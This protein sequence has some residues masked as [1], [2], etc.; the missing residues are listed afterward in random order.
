MNHQIERLDALSPLKILT[1]GYS[2][3]T[4]HKSDKPITSINK[5]V[6]GQKL[7]IFLADGVIHCTTDSIE[8]RGGLL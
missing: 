5:I 6:S 1:R 4:D 8:T 3:V 2:V 7:R